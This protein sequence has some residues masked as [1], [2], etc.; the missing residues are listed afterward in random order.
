MQGEE[1]RFMTGPGQSIDLVDGST[2]I[3]KADHAGGMSRTHSGP[4]PGERRSCAD[5]DQETD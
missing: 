1:A 2:T 4:I 5:R 3:K